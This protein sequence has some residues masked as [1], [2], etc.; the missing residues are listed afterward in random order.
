MYICTHAYTYIQ[1]YEWGNTY[2]FIVVDWSQ[3]IG[4]AKKKKKKRTK[5]ERN[6]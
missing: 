6:V 3:S 4:M 1:T 5:K 2:K